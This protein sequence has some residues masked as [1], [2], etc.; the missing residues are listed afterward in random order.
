[1]KKIIMLVLALVLVLG[2]VVFGVSAADETVLDISTLT[3]TKADPDGA[4]EY[5]HEPLA[6][7]DMG[8]STEHKFQ[9]R[10]YKDI[11]LTGENMDLTIAQMNDVTITLRNVTIGN[12]E[13]KCYYCGLG[14]VFCGAEYTELTLVLE[15][16]NT[17]YS[18]F[19]VF[20]NDSPAVI[21]GDGVL[22]IKDPDT[23]DDDCFVYLGDITLES[24][25]V[26]VEFEETGIWGTTISGGTLNIQGDLYNYYDYFLTVEDGKLFVGG[27][28]VW[29][30]TGDSPITVKGG[31]FT[32]TGLLT[33]QFPEPDSEYELTFDISGGK[34]N[35]G[36]A[37]LYNVDINIS[38][39]ETVFEGI[40]DYH[41]QPGPGIIARNLNITGGCV[42]A[43]AV[44]I[45]EGI[46]Y[47]YPPTVSVVV[48]GDINIADNCVLLAQEPCDVT[49][50]GGDVVSVIGGDMHVCEPHSITVKA[51][52]GEVK[53]TESA[54]HGETVT[55]E[56]KA[57][58]GYELETLTVNGEKIEGTSFEM[59]NEDV[60]IVA[61]FKLKNPPT[62]DMNITFMTALMAVA[63]ITGLGIK[64][65]RSI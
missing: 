9:L 18:D 2:C 22:N 23:E 26:N 36:A 32:V 59:P 28:M 8:D 31:E 43:G 1:M 39:G 19:Y 49:I 57:K 13:A 45:P 7:Y 38:G 46:S 48:Y 27:D 10:V 24:G 53:V 41:G 33:Q 60:K 30:A 17:I 40:A 62:S 34:V 25:T 63:V 56:L 54:V 42:K 50:G 4:W 47:A 5:I 6:A 65:I 58:E 12:D 35:I 3:E 15:G 64:K 61:V 51:E 20:Y 55:L 14:D 29:A 52:N 16:E 44:K 21:K 37:E 11:V